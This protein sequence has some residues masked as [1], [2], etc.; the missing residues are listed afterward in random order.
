MFYQVK[1]WENAHFQHTFEYRADTRTSAIKSVLDHVFET[2]DHVVA[3]IHHELV[4]ERRDELVSAEIGALAGISD[5]KNPEVGMLAWLPRLDSADA[6]HHRA[7]EYSDFD[8]QLLM[9]DQ[10]RENWFKPEHLSIPS[11]WEHMLMA[12]DTGHH[13]IDIY[14]E[15]DDR[16]VL[17]I[18]SPVYKR[19]AAD[20]PA[21]RRE[22]LLGFV[23]SEWDVAPLID[24]SLRTMPVG[25]ID[26]YLSDA[27]DPQN[28]P[29]YFHSSRTRSGKD[30]A[31]K[32]GVSTEKFIVTGEHRWRVRFEAA[33]AF[34]QQ[35][36]SF[37]ALQSMGLVLLLSFM[38][39]GYLWMT[40][41]RTKEIAETV[42][43]RTAEL[44]AE[45]NKLS[46]SMARYDNLVKSI[47]VGVYLFRFYNDDSMGFEYVS[48]NF[49]KI[50]GLDADAVLQDG[51]IAFSAAHHDDLDNLI[52]ANKAAKESLEPFRWE[53]RFIING[54]TRWVQ[55][56]SDITAVD[57]SGSLWSGVVSDITERKKAET[58]L[59]TLTKALEYAGEAAVVTDHDAVIEYIN[60]A[61]TKITGYS[62]EEIVGKK[63]NILKSSAQDP[64]FYKVL[65]D[66]ILR[67]DVWQGTLIDR[68]K[69]GTYYPALMSVAPIHDDSGKVT[70]FVSLQQDMSE[71]KRLEEQ[72]LQSQKMEAIGVLV[73]GIAHDFNNML[74]GIVGNTYMAKTRI[75]DDEKLLGNIEAIERISMRAAGMIKQLLTFARKEHVE[76][77]TFSLTNF[78]NEAIK[79]AAT[80]IP[81]S[82]ERSCETSPEELYIHGDS[83]QLQQV[84]MNLINNAKDAL[85]GI[86]N[87]K[88]SC[89]LKPYIADDSFWQRHPN[90]K[91]EMFACLTVSDNGGGIPENV[92]SKIFDPFFTT[93]GVGKGTGLGLAMVYGA[94]EGHMGAIEV[95][96]VPGEGTTFT[97]Y[98]PLVDAKPEQEQVSLQQA[99]TGQNELI[100]VADDEALIL[101][102][103]KS[104]LSHLGYRVIAAHNGEEAVQ[105]FERNMRDISLVVLDVVMPV[106]GG[107]DA[108]K[109][110]RELDE[111][112]PIIF[113]T[114]YD[115]GSLDDA[116][117]EISD[118]EIINKPFTVESLSQ[119]II[120]SLDTRKQN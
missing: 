38:L 69:D 95:D 94:I 58:K 37:T 112:L 35:H 65:W 50:L 80:A 70:H 8:Y 79:L 12:M 9:A 17:V 54:N 20:N 84:I 15:G 119:L 93:K 71:Y 26:Y 47:P 6:N 104:V 113:A 18:F 83:T 59:K 5:P 115:R 75:K 117:R 36:Q 34:L 30:Q 103:Y 43:Q 46:D 120:R 99:V 42:K 61:F 52:R 96:S 55:I 32:T 77:S 91:G 78:L 19:S 45:K 89:S 114:G 81:E 67:G 105:Q 108:A 90:C 27:S 11:R 3:V 64:S 63:P 72:F 56:E 10:N 13:Q 76:M 110:I 31:L 60:P 107:M 74:A 57:E 97:I 98:L 88:I 49:C 44:H 29:F 53:G 106:M 111:K 68:R 24:E 62:F 87:G 39:S 2:A 21:E 16:H 109:R 66:T 4:V 85:E 14:T 86:K 1:S 116:G 82:I 73:G 28:M 7:P 41:R 25:A 102:M 33:P 23:V 118:H 92:V 48:P 22:A 40:T 100:L 51:S 101:E